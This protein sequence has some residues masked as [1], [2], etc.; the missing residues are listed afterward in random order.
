M[1]QGTFASI[2]RIF[3]DKYETSQIWWRQI[4]FKKS[5]SLEE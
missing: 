3:S 1:I 4:G 5:G 2:D